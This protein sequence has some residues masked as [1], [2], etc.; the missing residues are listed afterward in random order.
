M[1]DPGLAYFIA[2]CAVPFLV[3]LIFGGILLFRKDDV[4]RLAGAWTLKPLAATPLMLALI[5]LTQDQAIRGYLV[6]AI[7]IGFTLIIMAVFRRLFFARRSMTPWVLLALDTIRWGSTFLVVWHPSQNPFADRL[8]FDYPGMVSGL[9]FLAFAMPVV[10]AVAALWLS[11]GES[12][13]GGANV[14]Q[15]GRGSIGI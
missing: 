13:Q 4:S 3:T 10:F 15:S 7:G 1:N 6:A 12:R 14:V 5:G 9:I 2:C 11:T 8:F